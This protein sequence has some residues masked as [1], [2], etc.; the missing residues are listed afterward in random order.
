MMQTFLY[1]QRTVLQIFHFNFEFV[2]SKEILLT[3]FAYEA[4]KLRYF[5]YILYITTILHS[6]F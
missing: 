5:K 6:P 3:K 2:F 4:R 1:K